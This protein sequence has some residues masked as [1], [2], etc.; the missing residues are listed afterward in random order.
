MPADKRDAVQTNISIR[1][2]TPADLSAVHA[3]LSRMRL[4]LDGVPER[5]G[6]FVVATDRENVV[7]VAGL[8]LTDG[9]AALL[10]SV[11]VDDRYRRLGIAAGLVDRTIAD[12]Q[13]E[14]LKGLYLLTTTA[15]DYFAHRGFVVTERSSVPESLRATA[16]FEGACPASATVMF[17]DLRATTIGV[18]DETTR[19]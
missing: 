14:G 12:A 9:A 3:L 8:E 2:A 17:L 1:E 10:R 13:A 7:G 18:T 16:E 11:A 5:L 4:P 6:H 19:P 15:A